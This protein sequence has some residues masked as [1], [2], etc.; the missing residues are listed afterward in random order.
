MFWRLKMNPTIQELHLYNNPFSSAN[1]DPE[2]LDDP[3][4]ILESMPEV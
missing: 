2:L 4:T 1:V 3:R